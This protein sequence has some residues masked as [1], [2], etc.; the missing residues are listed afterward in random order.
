MGDQM[1]VP[2]H[3]LD[4]RDEL[5]HRVQE[6]DHVHGFR[7]PAPEQNGCLTRSVNETANPS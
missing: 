3:E 4:E 5:E 6:T 2:P 1:L 7:V